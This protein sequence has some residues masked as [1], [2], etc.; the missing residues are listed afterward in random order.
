M[1]S[2]ELQKQLD[3][4]ASEVQLYASELE[5]EIARLHKRILK[6]EVKNRSYES[7]IDALEEELS[8]YTEI[9]KTEYKKFTLELLQERLGRKAIEGPSHEDYL[10]LLKEAEDQAKRNENRA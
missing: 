8:V 6:L 1:R 4:S 7:K 2:T 5:A 10:R 9:P 3:Q